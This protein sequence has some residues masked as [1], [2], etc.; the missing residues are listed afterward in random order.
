MATEK[1]K[2]YYVIAK[3]REQTGQEMSY[4]DELQTTQWKKRREE[5][6]T[7][8]NGACVMCNHKPS[9]FK[10]PENYRDMTDDERTKFVDEFQAEFSE[11]EKKDYIEIFGFLPQPAFILVPKYDGLPTKPIVLNVHHKLYVKTRLAWEYM[12]EELITYC[13]DCHQAVHDSNDIPFYEDETQSEAFY[14][15]PCAKCNGSGYLSEFSY[16]LNGKCFAC[17][18]NKYLDF[19]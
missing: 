19:K 2:D 18:G 6:I 5:I 10:N 7:R 4:Q 3:E 16:Y 13:Q 9:D 1:I 8:D 17:D 12:D 11:A 15:K 14:L